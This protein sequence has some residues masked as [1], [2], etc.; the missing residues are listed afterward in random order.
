MK[1][2]AKK[3]KSKF[4][5]KI[6]IISILLAYY[7]G[8]IGSIFTS[9]SVKTQWYEAIKPSITPSGKFIGTVWN[10]LFFL[11]AISLYLAFT[12]KSAKTKQRNLLYSLFAINLVLNGVWSFLFFGLRNTLAGFTEII[13]LW[14][15][16]LSLVIYA[17]RIDKRIS[18]LLIPYLLWVGFASYINFLSAF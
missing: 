9:T 7:T 10:V 16:I 8:A 12:N 13:L 11:I 15:S 18:Y 1:K 4:N 14:V 5:F 6:F 3:T 2:E 17:W